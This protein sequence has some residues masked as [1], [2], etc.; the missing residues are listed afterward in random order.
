[1]LR[2]LLGCCSLHRHSSERGGLLHDLPNAAAGG[3]THASA[4]RDK[5]DEY[6]G[7]TTEKEGL[8]HLSMKKNKKGGATAAGVG[9]ANSAMVTRRFVYMVTEGID[10][11]VPCTIHLCMYNP[12]VRT[13]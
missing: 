11:L 6:L 3:L 9:G 7:A 12:S 13:S 8:P 4:A 1:M 2:S 5:G 10:G